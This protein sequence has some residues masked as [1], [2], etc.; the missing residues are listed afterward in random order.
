MNCEKT[1]IFLNT[2]YIIERTQFEADADSLLVR[3]CMLK[4]VHT[5]TR[6]INIIFS[7][8]YDLKRATGLLQK[9]GKFESQEVGTFC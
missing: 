2:L 3:L 5:C 6:F 1:Q 4:R 8:F 9:S 7:R